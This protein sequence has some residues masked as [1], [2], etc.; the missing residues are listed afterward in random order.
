MRKSSEPLVVLN[1]WVKLNEPFT[2]RL[3]PLKTLWFI[4]AA[5]LPLRSG[6]ENDLMVGDHLNVRKCMEGHS[7]GKVANHCSRRC[8]LVEGPQQRLADARHWTHDL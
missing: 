6:S 1:L 8:S 3:K 2:G 5:K 4:T 7:T